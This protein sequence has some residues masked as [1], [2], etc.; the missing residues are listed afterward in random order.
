M[1]K[2]FQELKIQFLKSDGEKKENY[3]NKLRE[4]LIQRNKEVSIYTNKYTQTKRTYD[5]AKCDWKELFEIDGD[6]VNFEDKNT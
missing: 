1:N 6:M 3:L 4:N 2:E 5:I